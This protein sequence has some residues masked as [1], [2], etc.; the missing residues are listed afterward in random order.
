MG[1]NIYGKINFNVF[2][3]INPLPFFS[4][5]D[6]IR[7]KIIKEALK[8]NPTL[9]KKQ[10]IPKNKKVI[11]PFLFSEKKLTANS[12]I[13]RSMEYC[14]RVRELEIIK[15]LKQN[16]ASKIKPIFNGNDL[17]RI[18]LNKRMDAQELKKV[19]ILS[20]I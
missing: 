4:R 5:K 19:R 11:N 18:L 17:L 8:N 3:L 7:L 20:E 13:I 6:L 16:K 2:Q 12:P 15:G 1:A 14:L 10:K 9:L